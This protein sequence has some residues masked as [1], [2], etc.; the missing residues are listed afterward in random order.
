[1][2]LLN[3]KYVHV[4]TYITEQSEYLS[5]LLP[6]DVVLANHGF[7]VA[8]SVAQQGASCHIPAS[9]KG[10]EQATANEVE[11]KRRNDNSCDWS[12]MS[13]LHFVSKRISLK[14]TYI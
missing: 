3:L 7:D 1:M 14:L 2:A 8:D 4:S 5:I 9:T 6:G 11:T 13:D 10:R 12:C